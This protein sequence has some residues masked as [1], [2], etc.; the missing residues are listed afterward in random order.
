M[1]FV[2][3]NVDA[4]MLRRLEDRLAAMLCDAAEE[5][6]HMDCL[7]DE[8]RSEIYTILRALR[9]DGEMHRGILAM[10]GD[11]PGEYVPDA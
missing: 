1:E 11:N 9:A 8:Q 4:G 6:E 10:L 2:E 5:V 7:D 3:K